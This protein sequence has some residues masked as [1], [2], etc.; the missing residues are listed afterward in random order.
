M[1]RGALT[2][3][4]DATSAGV[5]TARYI[6]KTLLTCVLLTDPQV[7]VHREPHTARAC[8]VLARVYRVTFRQ[9]G[10]R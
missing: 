6:L 4:S 7:L 10:D 5:L 2:A 1:A 3:R 9:R 8:A